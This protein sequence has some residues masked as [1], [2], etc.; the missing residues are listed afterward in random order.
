MVQRMRQLINSL[1]S[2][3][4]DG[5]A[6]VKLQH[7][8]AKNLVQL[9]QQLQKNDESEGKVNNV[10]YAADAETN[11]ILVSG[12]KENLQQAT[13]LI[14]KL[15]QSSSKVDS[16]LTVIHLNYVAATTIVPILAK[17]AG[18]NVTSTGGS[19]ASSGSQG[20]ALG[21]SMMGA[22]NGDSNN[23]MDN[24]NGVNG[25]D[26]NWQGGAG[27]DS[28]GADTSSIFQTQQVVSGGGK[29]F[30]L[31]AV[32]STNN[33]IVSAPA[34]MVTKLKQI[35]KLLD[36]RPKQVLV[37]ALIV[38]INQKLMSQLGI[39]W[40]NMENGKFISGTGLIE[41]MS[42][43]GIWQALNDDN[44]SDILAT[45]T[46]VVQNNQKAMIADGKTI[47]ITSTNIAQN[48]AQSDNVNYKN[49]LLT[50]QVKPQ[51]NNN[52]SVTLTIAQQDNEVDQ[53][54]VDLSS[55][56]NTPPG[57]DT[58]TI[59]TQVMVPNSDVL[60]LGGLLKN[61]RTVNKTGIP[62]LSKIPL[63][64]RLFTLQDVNHV[65]QNLVIFLKPTVLKDEDQDIKASHKIY[66]G[67]RNQQLQQS[68]KDSP[69]D[70]KLDPVLPRLKTNH[71]VALP[72]PFKTH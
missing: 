67:L 22:A 47:P 10:S 62:I 52:N 15:D 57:F 65:K 27:G 26:N 63:I 61:E 21:Q 7:A 31:V 20:S 19:D 16:G 50:L 68:A 49:V 23:M 1:D 11:S 2:N 55:D 36:V 48:G 70:M 72:Q 40:G 46:V 8:T 41:H 58:S 38:R 71:P 3:S 14:H 4:G 9:L 54:D 42:I 37:Q 25:G 53:S 34:Q 28:I 35:V 12:N 56:A 66:T 59:T 30:S 51:I 64:G 5:L 24:S 69:S 39:Q 60:V 33:I 43:A 13:A 32:P 29:N 6:D 17:L 44:D 18:G 45:P